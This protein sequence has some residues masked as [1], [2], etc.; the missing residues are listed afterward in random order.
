MVT[1][2]G[3]NPSWYPH[4]VLMDHV[5]FPR[6]FWSIWIQIHLPPPKKRDKKLF[7]NADSLSIRKLLQSGLSVITYKYTVRFITPLFFG[8][9]KKLDL[10]ISFRPFIGVRCFTPSITIVFGPTAKG[11]F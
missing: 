8:V 11:E 4:G 1:V 3:T 2:S 6:Y 9:R 10:P 7:S 5:K